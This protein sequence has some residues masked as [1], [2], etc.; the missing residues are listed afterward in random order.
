MSYNEFIKYSYTV[1]TFNQCLHVKLGKGVSED[2]RRDAVIEAY[3]HYNANNRDHQF[4]HPDSIVDSE[5]GFKEVIFEKD[6]KVVFTPKVTIIYSGNQQLH[7]LPYQ[8]KNIV[9]IIATHYGV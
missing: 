3:E 1:D 5:P 6:V 7:F 9:Q 8:A 2:F 4:I